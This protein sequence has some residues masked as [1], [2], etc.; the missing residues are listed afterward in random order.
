MNTIYVK[1]ISLLIF[2][3]AI[4]SCTD[5]L[6]LEP[7]SLVSNES[8]WKTADQAA[9]GLHGMYYRAR[10][11]ANTNLLL[12]GEARSE[13]WVQ[14]FGMDASNAFP[15]F[16]NDLSRTNAGPDWTGMY[17]A[18]HDANLILKYVPDIDFVNE[19]EKNSMLAQAHAMRAFLYFTMTKVWG[20]LILNEEPTEGFIPETTFKER[21]SQNDVFQLI[22]RDIEDALALFPDNSFS[23]HRCY[24]SKPAVNAL[25]ADVNLWTSKKLNGGTD[26]LNTA[27]NAIAEIEGSDVELLSDFE[28]IFDYNNK[29][30][31]EIIMSFRYFEGES[32]TRLTLGGITGLDAPKAEYTDAETMEKVAPM[33]G[34]KNSHWQIANSVVEQFY[35]DD[36]RKDASLIQVFET[37]DGITKLLYNVDQKWDGIMSGGVMA[38][39]NDYILYRY[40][41]VI[42]M[43][44]EAKSALGQ[45]PSTEINEIRKR[46]FGDNYSDHIFE[47]GTKEYN[48]EVILQERLFE[49][50][51]EGKRWWDLVR[52]DKALELVPLLEGK[53]ENYLLF[54]IAEDILSL[55]P[56]VEQNPGYN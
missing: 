5:S 36:L 3:S 26:D 53:D 20:D 41:D 2:F 18:V 11:Q 4:F 23:S 30:N 47:S 42:L 56:L 13:I 32:S 38:H 29:G 51:H 50:Y 48:D 21:S 33:I 49:F 15:V 40:A 22:K 37:R 10:N 25:K 6:N 35:D 14:N 17:S 34:S 39:Y 43:K 27:L 9:G 1:L 8:F 45:D 19:S 7:I 24:W 16:M 52:F 28:Q 46:A 54:P 12:W 44:A 31:K 55:E